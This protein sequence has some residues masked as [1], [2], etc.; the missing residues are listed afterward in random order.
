MFKLLNDIQLT[1]N[2][3]ISEFECHDDSHEVMLEMKLVELLQKLR[4]RLG[5]PLTL[6]SG[7]RNTNHN[8]A[9]GGSPNSRHMLGQAADVKCRTFNPKQVATAA[10]LCGFTGIGTYMHNAQWFNH[11]DIRPV[12][13]LW[14][15]N[16]GSYNLTRVK[17]IEEIRG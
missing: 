5:V 9:V 17:T 6:E 7:Y 3:K 12:K 15:D 11:L 10:L 13:S 1:K 16:Q 2:F 8:H 14:H 4:D